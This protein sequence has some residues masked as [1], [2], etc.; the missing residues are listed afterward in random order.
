MQR[1]LVNSLCIGVVL[2]SDKLGGAITAS[3][4]GN[5]HAGCIFQILM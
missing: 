1:L 4:S 2:S 3:E 5:F